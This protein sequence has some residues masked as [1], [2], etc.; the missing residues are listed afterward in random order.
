M[1]HKNR[2]V[3][4]L[5]VLLLT[6]GLL[7]TACQSSPETE[8]AAPVKTEEAAPVKTEEAA[9]AET[10]AAA[11]ASYVIGFSNASTSNSWRAFFDAWVRYEASR[12]P[13]IEKLIDTDAQ[14]DPVKQISDIE[15]LVAQGVDLLIISPAEQEALVPAVE[16]AMEAG[17]PVVLVDRKVNTDKYVSFVGASDTD[18]GKIMAEELVKM[19][20]YAEVNT[21]SFAT[22][23][24]LMALTRGSDSQISVPSVALRH[25]T[26]RGPFFE[27]GAL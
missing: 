21:K 22:L 26:C 20:P 24:T 15:D 19:S 8:E 10:E 17:I 13:E 12:H 23:T 3:S 6:A 16:G 11:E 1:S 4:L 7:L 2:Y 25:Q 27:C 5:I 14:D 9:P 18:M